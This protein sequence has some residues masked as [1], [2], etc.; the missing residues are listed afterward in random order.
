MPGP[1]AYNRH[2][3][4][5]RARADPARAR[6]HGDRLPGAQQ[7]GAERAARRLPARR[8]ELTPPA[9]RQGGQ[10]RMRL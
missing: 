5:G 1:R 9:P 10:P 6:R 8:A 4:G 7:G 3:H 2:D